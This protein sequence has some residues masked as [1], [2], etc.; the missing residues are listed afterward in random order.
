MLTWYRNSNTKP[1]SAYSLLLLLPASHIITD[2][3]NTYI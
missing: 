3:I 1:I 2:I